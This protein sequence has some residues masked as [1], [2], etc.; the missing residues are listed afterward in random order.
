MENSM[1]QRNLSSMTVDALLKLRDEVGSVLSRR[2]DD[3]KT[4]LK[5]IGADYADVG[6]IAVF[7]KKSLRG[8]K[9][10][11]K[12]RDKAGNTWAG[13]GAQPL[14][15]TE[16]IKKGAKRD[17]FLVSKPVRE[18]MKRKAARKGRPKKALKKAA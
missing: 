7:G 5:A 11:I 12:Y 4:E 10:P 16:A 18:S 14:W 6:R 9:V 13:R 1:V 3:L 17:D 15:M 8:R 2:A